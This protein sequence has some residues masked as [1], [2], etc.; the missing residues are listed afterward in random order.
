MNEV[1]HQCVATVMVHPKHVL[2]MA[3]YCKRCSHLCVAEGKQKTL[4]NPDQEMFESLLVKSS[5]SQPPSGFP[6]RSSTREE[7][8]RVVIRNFGGT[9]KCW[10]DRLESKIRRR[11]RFFL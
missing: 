8:S 11:H 1:N 4:C 7:E 2:G 5:G 6:V 3:V 9:L 10:L